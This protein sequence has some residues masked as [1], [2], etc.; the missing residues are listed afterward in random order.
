MPIKGN[1]YLPPVDYFAVTGEK[2]QITGFQVGKNDPGCIF[3]DHSTG[4]S[5]SLFSGVADN[6]G[7]EKI[8]ASGA[9]GIY[10]ASGQQKNFQMIFIISFN[11]NQRS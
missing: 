4:L 11:L 1:F 2:W 10:S 8:D 6:N 9:T 5:L 7:Y 3:I